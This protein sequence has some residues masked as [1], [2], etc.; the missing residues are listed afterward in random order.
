MIISPRMGGGHNYETYWVGCSNN[1]PITRAN[2]IQS[3]IPNDF[4]SASV[5]AKNLTEVLPDEK[6]LSLDESKSKITL[7]S[8][9][10]CIG[11]YMED[12]GINTVFRVYD[13]D[14][15]T[16]V[17]LL[18]DWGAAKGGKFYK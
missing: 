5:I 3:Q 14:L 18:Y 2:S 15:K 7:T 10:A 16:E 4:C 8:W 6:K 9:I 1:Y 12:N 11:S 13:P 17:Y